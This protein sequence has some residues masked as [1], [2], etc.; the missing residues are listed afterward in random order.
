MS[1]LEELIN[2]RAARDNRANAYNAEVVEQQEIEAEIIRKYCKE[3]KIFNELEWEIYV[4]FNYIILRS[5]S[6]NDVYLKSKLYVNLVTRFGCSYEWFDINVVNRG[7]SFEFYIR[8][9]EDPSKLLDLIKEFDLKVYGN[10][11]GTYIEQE[12]D[13]LKTLQELYYFCKIV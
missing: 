6:P 8:I 13:R 3:E 4:D 11:L 7:A 2:N 12:N 9:T 5:I 1:L 10:P